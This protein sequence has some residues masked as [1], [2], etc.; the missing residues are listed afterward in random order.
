MWKLSPKLGCGN[1]LLK[2]KFNFLRMIILL[3]AT[4][5]FERENSVGLGFQIYSEKTIGSYCLLS[6]NLSIVLIPAVFL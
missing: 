4:E 3:P 2:V 6:F 1:S 5:A